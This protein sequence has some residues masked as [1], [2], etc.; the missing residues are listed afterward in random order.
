VVDAT[1]DLVWSRNLYAIG[2]TTKLFKDA[3]ARNESVADA[4]GKASQRAATAQI[5]GFS[6]WRLATQKEVESLLGRM[7]TATVYAYFRARSV[8]LPISHVIATF[9]AGA[10]AEH[11]TVD[12]MIYDNTAG[13]RARWGI[14]SPEINPYGVWLVRGYAGEV[15]KGT[16][17]V[18]Q[19]LRQYLE[20]IEE[21]RLSPA[22]VY[23]VVKRDEAV[24]L[25][26][27]APKAAAKV[28]TT[29]ALNTR[30][31]TRYNFKGLPRA[32][33]VTAEVQLRGRS[34]DGA[35]APIVK[36]EV[37]QGSA[38][39]GALR[40]LWAFAKPTPVGIWQMP[41]AA[42]LELPGHIARNAYNSA[43]DLYLSFA[44]SYNTCEFEIPELIVRYVREQNLL[45]RRQLP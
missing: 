21:L 37:A 23:Q 44:A 27:M 10:P 40:E 43:D 22:N 31:Y 16:A 15:E 34:S 17:A 12:G 20:P 25:L 45:A 5:G 28:S 29:P 32:T 4:Y 7:P 6:G 36:V 8:Q 1:Q 33:L 14:G 18:A 19:P 13:G 42:R 11:V 24:E 41:E 30:F 3:Y 26:S 2:D 9:D 39:S 35:P 38:Q